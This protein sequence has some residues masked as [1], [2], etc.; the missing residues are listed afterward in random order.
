MMFKAIP[1]ARISTERIAAT[2]SLGAS[3]D[4]FSDPSDISFCLLIRCIPITRAT[5]AKKNVAIIDPRLATAGICAAA[6]AASEDALK[7]SGSNA[8]EMI[9]IP[10]VRKLLQR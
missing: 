6:L 5:G 8:D 10:P 7:A 9:A 2:M 3:L 4:F 1:P